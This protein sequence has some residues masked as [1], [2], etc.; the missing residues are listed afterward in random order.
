MRVGECVCGVGG[1][2][3]DMRLG[4]LLEIGIG[5]LWNEGDFN[6]CGN[7]KRKTEAYKYE[8]G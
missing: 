7:D 3:E 8:R 1:G 2:G 6:F 5:I 4:G